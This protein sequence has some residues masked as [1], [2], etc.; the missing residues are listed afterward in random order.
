[1]N[2]IKNYKKYLYISFFVLVLFLIKFSTSKVY[3]NIY[4]IEDINVKEPYDVNF[5]KTKVVDKAFKIAFRELIKK[6]ITTKNIK[7]VDNIKIEE[8]KKLIDS[9][10]IIDE[11]FVNKNYSA[12]FNVSFEK[13]K[14]LNYLIKKNIFSSIPIK[15]KIFLIPIYINLEENQILL[16]SE[17]KFYLNW[18]N[19]IQKHHLLNYVLPNED[20][21]DLVVIKKNIKN[22]EEYD[23]KEIINKYELYDY[24]IL[25]IYENDQNLNTL[26]K[27]NLNNKIYILR[28]KFPKVSEDNLSTI[29]LLK[30]SYEDQWKDLNIIN[31]SIKL[32]IK[33]KIKANDY[34]KINFLEQYLNKMNLVNNFKIDTFTNEDVVYEIIY[35]GTPDKFLFEFEKE[36]IKIDISKDLWEI[37]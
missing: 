16:F 18:N 14:F 34:K 37:K 12:L 1:M 31:T 19:E 6:T 30:N 21:D 11:N 20:L 23:F 17:N 36:D 26:T 3:A 9:F 7:L 8:I 5:D 13:K 10:E 22:I 33:L 2:F 35:N 4:K 15:K 27:I 25:F 24:I 28:N 29:N 32:K